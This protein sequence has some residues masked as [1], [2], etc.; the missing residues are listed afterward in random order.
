MPPYLGGVVVPELSVELFGMLPPPLDGVC[1]FMPLPLFIEPLLPAEPPFAPLI[2]E[3]PELLPFMDEDD[4]LLI[5]PLFIA[6]LFMEPLF[7]EPPLD[8]PCM[9][10]DPGLES[11]C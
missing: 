2:D 4:E 7:I 3:P 9:P 5:E 10:D 8:P 6:P 1:E 11:C